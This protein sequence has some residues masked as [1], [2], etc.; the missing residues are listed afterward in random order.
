MNAVGAHVSPPSVPRDTR[1]RA[2]P[3]ETLPGVASTASACTDVF[4]SPVFS[5]VHVAA[6][7]VLFQNPSSRAPTKTFVGVTGSIAIAEERTTVIGVLVH[8]DPPFVVL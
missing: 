7:S 4:A 2:A 6:P 3:A 1:L 5:W 8:V